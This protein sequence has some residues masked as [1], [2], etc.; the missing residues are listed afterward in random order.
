MHLYERK[1]LV[2][3]PALREF[4]KR[5]VILKSSYVQT[6][7]KLIACT[8]LLVPNGTTLSSDIQFSPSAALV[9][10]SVDNAAT[11]PKVC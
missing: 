4:L 2:E 9:I 11:W 1:P 3:T 8:P 5:H 6:M 7:S 10:E